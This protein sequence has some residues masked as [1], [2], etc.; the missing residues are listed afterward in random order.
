MAYVPVILSQIRWG[1]IK[2]MLQGTYL[3]TN[4]ETDGDES[5]VS[6]PLDGPHL[7]LEIH[8]GSATYQA[9]LGSNQLQV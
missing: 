1:V 7:A 9:L 5:S 6:V 8:E 4:H 3:L 2:R